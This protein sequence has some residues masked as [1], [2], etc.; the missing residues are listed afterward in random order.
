MHI[1]PCSWMNCRCCVLLSLSHRSLFHR[2]LPHIHLH[3]HTHTPPLFPPTL[4]LSP[5]TEVFQKHTHTHTCAVLLLVTF[6]PGQMQYLPPLS[7]TFEAR[8]S[9]WIVIHCWNTSAE[10]P[11]GSSTSWRG[12]AA[13]VRI[14]FL[15]SCLLLMG[16]WRDSGTE[17]DWGGEDGERS[18]VRNCR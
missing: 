6:S 7:A 15:A 8:Y 10:S 2:K 18:G 14:S 11:F 9:P 12:E 16:T 5:G 4:S 1:K 13:R 3:T 17:A